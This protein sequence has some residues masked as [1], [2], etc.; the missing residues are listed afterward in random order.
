MK[1]KLS[2]RLLSLLKNIVRC[3]RCSK[4]PALRR[5]IGLLLHS[6]LINLLNAGKLISSVFAKSQK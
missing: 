3:L 4:K 6:R 1:I 5:V 2:E